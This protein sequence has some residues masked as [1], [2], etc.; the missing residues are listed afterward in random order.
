MFLILKLKILKKIKYIYIYAGLIWINALISLVFSVDFANSIYGFV[1]LSFG[2]IVFIISLS[3]FMSDDYYKNFDK[4]YLNLCGLIS[5]LIIFAY[6]NGVRLNDYFDSYS[7]I[8]VD[9][10][11]ITAATFF[12][13]ATFFY[14]NI[15]YILGVGSIIAFIKIIYLSEL[16]WKIYFIIINIAIIA[17]FNK[18]TFIALFLVFFI[19]IYSR[20]LLEKKM[21]NYSIIIIG[22]LFVYI[23]SEYLSY[24]SELERMLNFSS[25]S[26]RLSLF[27]SILN[28]FI[29]QPIRILVGFGPDTL[30][31]S[32]DVSVLAFKISENGNEGTVD[33]GL[34]SYFIE[35]GLFFT[36][37]LYLP[38]L[39]II[40][41]LF[42]IALKYN[43]V[44]RN[45]KPLEAGSAIL[46]MVICSIPQ[47]LSVGP[48]MWTCSIYLAFAVSTILRN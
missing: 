7:G 29:E 28:P 42:K 2:I 41:R 1:N 18:T 31:R 21:I 32:K 17:L 45:L 37:F 39:M 44:N 36:L 12:P 48:V 6:I 38:I 22:A 3:F 13:K 20:L 19:I 35:Y 24:F 14:N 34:F 30:L 11:I 26:A 5:L 23:F 27:E 40:I 10:E 43:T 15:F 46:F 16:K 25:A 8:D 9:L 4:F 47:V 33:S